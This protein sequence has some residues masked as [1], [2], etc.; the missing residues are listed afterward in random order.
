MTRRIFP[1]ASA[2]GWLLTAVLL[3]VLAGPA[4]GARISG[5]DPETEPAASQPPAAQDQKA[6][7]AAEEK[8]V[9]INFT[10]VDIEKIIAWMSKTTGTNFVVDKRVKGKVTVISDRRIP[11][12]DAYRVFLSILE[13]YGFTAVDAGEVVKIIPLPDAR[14]KPVETRLRQESGKPEDRVITQV[15]PLQY[16]DPEEIKKLFQPMISKSS[17]MVSYAPT[18]TL[19]ITDVET[20]IQRLMRILTVIDVMGIDQ[21]ISVIPLAH[22]SSQEMVKTMMA[23]FTKQ[24]APRSRATPEP[25]RMVA[26]DRTNSL[27]VLASSDD[28]RAVKELV[29]MLDRQVP[30]GEGKIRVYYLQNATA[31]DVAAVL[32]KISSQ[33]AA[34]PAGAKGEVPII[35]R[36]VQ[37]S[38]DKATNSLIITANKEDYSILEDV[39]MK[40]DLPRAMVYIEALIMEVSTDKNFDLGVEWRGGDDFEV[41]G[42]KGGYF[43]GSGGGGSQ[44]AYNIFP[45]PTILGDTVAMGFPSAFSIG[46]VGEFIRI[47]DVVFPNIGAVLRAYKQDSD[48][49]ILSAPQLL[50]T[51]NEEAE[52]TVGKN[53]PYVTRQE[54]S[55]ASVDYSTFEYKDVGVT[56]KITPQI[57]QERLVRLKVFQEVTRLIETSGT[58]TQPTTFKRSTDTTVI[59]KDGNTIVIGGLIDESTEGSV[60][61]VP[62]L[63]DIPV[64]GW[65]FKSVSEKRQKTNLYVFLTPHIIENPS[66]AN[67]IFEDKRGEI[68][69]IEEGTIEMYKRKGALTLPFGPLNGQD[70]I[71]PAV[72]NIP[73]FEPE[74]T[75]PVVEE[76]PAGN[77]PPLSQDLPEPSLPDEHR[78]P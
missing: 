3:C 77:E 21:E 58:T 23:L 56:L 55:S 73:S 61:R 34:G 19:L 74:A 24:R 30:R 71:P 12:E 46:V 39:I 42:G 40:L 6:T 20:N 70:D 78:E 29:E 11:V 15:V 37:I 67:E 75:E 2:T 18:N 49:H 72:D 27:V 35:S 36:D 63:G 22:A 31:E 62:C 5:A 7:A 10:D 28:T 54:T 8:T 25:I 47:G 69:G 60:Y 1:W 44:G 33:K 48:V 43:M 41:E 14:D 32:E 64:L 13:V 57:S 65:L 52:I 76:G 4:A 53:V 38:P 51:N 50:T 17:I 66:E 59:V 45:T 16:A 68:Q 9:S 26:D